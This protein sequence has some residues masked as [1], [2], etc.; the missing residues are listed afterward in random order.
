MFRVEGVKEVDCFGV[1]IIV[2]EMGVR[3]VPGEGIFIGGVRMGTWSHGDRNRC[4]E[5]VFWVIW[6]ERVGVGWRLGGRDGEASDAGIVIG[7][8]TRDERGENG[9]VIW[10]GL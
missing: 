10:K 4:K 6:W 3:S 9:C 5:V 1:G 7:W 2:K 8:E